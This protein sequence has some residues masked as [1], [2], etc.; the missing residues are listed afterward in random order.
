MDTTFDTGATGLIGSNILQ[1]LLQRGRKVKVLVRSIER[2]KALLPESCELVQGDI[3]DPAAV[4]RAMEGCSVV[5]HTAGYHEQWLPD[6]AE[7]Q[8]VNV[9][10]T[11][12]MLEA[13]LAEE[14]A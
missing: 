6:P 9:G 3:T 5:Y 7:F 4:R 1:A 12:N 2:G 13:A 10:G 14:Q 8:R 11:Q